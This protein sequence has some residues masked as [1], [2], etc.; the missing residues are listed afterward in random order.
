MTSIPCILNRSD[1]A[2]H[3]RLW[4]GH[5]LGKDLGTNATVLFYATDEIG[6]GAR[7]H[8]H[9]YDEMF[10]IRSGRA[11]FTV[12]GGKTE[13]VAGQ[14]VMC[15]SEVPHKFVNLGPELLEII[16]VHL[17]DTWIQTNLDDPQ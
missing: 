9:P 5:F 13:V 7:L 4:H 11:A 12:G 15:P 10:I 16:S 14:V 2:S 17:S 8:T 3:N 1:W 6:K